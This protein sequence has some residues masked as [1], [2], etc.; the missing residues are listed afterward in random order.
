MP[1]TPGDCISDYFIDPAASA[2]ER[3][4]FKHFVAELLIGS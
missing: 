2:F 1:A 4:L 3:Q